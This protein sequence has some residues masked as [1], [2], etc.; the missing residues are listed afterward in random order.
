MG[1]TRTMLGCLGISGDSRPLSHQR[2]RNFLRTAITWFA[3]PGELQSVAEI[4][5]C[6]PRLFTSLNFVGWELNLN[7]F[8]VSPCSPCLRGGLIVGRNSPRRHREHGEELK[9]GH[10]T[11]LRTAVTGRACS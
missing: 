2:G 10:Y 1:G 7:S 3:D 5:A 4:I 8:S 11:L 6:Y 9:P